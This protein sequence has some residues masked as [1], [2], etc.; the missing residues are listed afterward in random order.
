MRC[1]TSPS[2]ATACSDRGLLLRRPGRRW[3]ARGQEQHRALQHGPRLRRHEDQPARGLTFT[4]SVFA[5]NLGTGLWF[6]ESIYNATITGNDLLRNAGHGISYEISSRALIA[7][8]V[9]AGN[10]GLGLK[11]NNASNIDI[12]NN[13]I[14]DNGDRPIWLVQDPRVASNAN[15]PGHDPRQAQPDPR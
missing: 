14:V 5:D 3:D 13:T 15:T 7:D 6:D 11:I 8:N 2:S 10:G 12:W 9:V 1:G 4:D